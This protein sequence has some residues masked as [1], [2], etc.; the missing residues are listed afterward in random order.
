M[1][2][3]PSSPRPSMRRPAAAITLAALWLLCLLIAPSASA[4]AVPFRNFESPQVHPLAITPDGTRL[5][6]VNSPNGTLSVFQITSGS[7]VLTAEI[8]VGLEP[9]SVAARNDREAWIVNWLSDSVSIVDLTTGNVVRTIDVGDEPTDVLFGGSGR[10]MAFVCV[11]GGGLAANGI[12]G[13]SGVVKVFDPNNL[14]AAP[15]VIDVPGKQPRAL[16][17]STD[18]SRVF[19][20][21]FESGNQ[22]T[23]VPGPFVRDGGGLPPPSPSMRAGLPAAPVTGLIVKW[24]GG[25]WV[26]ETDRSWTRF[27]PYSLSDIDLIVIDATGNTVGT[28][29]GV[30]ELGTHVGNMAFD[31]AAQR[32]FVANRED[33][34]QVR[35][36][37]NL[38]GR[39]Q[40]SRVSVVN[41]PMGMQPSI[42]AVSDLNA[43]V[44]FGNPSGTDSE[45]S[46]SLA[47][48]ADI[49][50]QS[51]GTV[52]VAAT[53]SARVGVL[54]SSGAVRGR[55]NVGRGPTG[56]AL[57]GARQRLYV[58]NRFDETM[59]VVDTNS[60]TQV[61]QVAVGFNP[62]PASVRD[63]RRFLY[64]SSLSAH[65]TVSC[66][67]C[68]L[69]GH[70]DGMAWDLGD[71]QGNVDILRDFLGLGETS[72]SV[73]PM[74]G[75]MMTQSLRGLVGVGP[76]HWRGD[77][78]DIRA[79]NPA[80]VSLLGGTR[81]L[82]TEEMNA[83]QSFVLSITYPPNPNEKL[84]R[85]LT[86]QDAHARDLFMTVKL[87]TGSDGSGIKTCNECHQIDKFGTSGLIL[88]VSDI[89]L[90]EQPI[91]I[92]Q[93]RGLYQKTGMER[94][95]GDKRGTGFGFVRDG[96]F[97]TII[98]FLRAPTFIFDPNPDTAESQ[99]SDMEHML[100]AFD[101]GTAPTV[102]LMV[103]VNGD[104]KNSPEI[105]NRLQLLMQRSAAGDCDLVVHGL[106]GGG[107]H[108]FL[109]LADGTFQPDSLSEA[110]V[111]LQTLLNAAGAGA[112][113]TFTGVAPGEGRRRA[114]DGDGDGLL[115][116]DDPP[117]S[118]S[119]TG[120][121]VDAHGAGIAGVAVSLTGTQSGTA[122]TDALG[123][124]VFN[125]VLTS[126]THTVTPTSA[127]TTFTPASRT[128]SNPTWNQSAV[129]AASSTANASDSSEFF[130]AQHYRDFL[131]REPDASGLA[132]WTNEI[133]Q[134]GTNAQ[135]RELKRVNVSGAFFLSIEFQQTGYLVYRTSK[136][137][138]G[139]LANK[140][141]PVTVAR[142]MTDAQRLGR[143]VVV[144]RA[145]WEQLLETNKLAFF[146]G[147]VQRPEFI[148][149]YP[150]SMAPVDFVS[151]LNASAGFPLNGVEHASLVAQLS[152]NN[153]TQGRAAVLRQVAENAVFSARERNRAFV[154]MQYFGYLR[155]DPNDAP[156]PNLDFAGYN[157]WLT[158]LNDFDGNHVSA[159]MVKAFIAS[160]EYRHRFGQ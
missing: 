42:I 50:C 125:Y 143:G 138:F 90:G 144:G 130:V 39:F 103:T 53:G 22:T 105:V 94:S 58:L 25:A 81:Q 123:R 115:N 18:G 121:V 118:V 108:G 80:F 122:M 68:H 132:F 56:L 154:L 13:G 135:C 38:R 85:G 64:D 141:V 65:G 83:F 128:F 86:E 119:I 49:V 57:D 15:Q 19:V 46:L 120:Q 100:L 129:F 104:N 116:D 137:S 95:Q 140:P 32:L 117:S 114:I 149:R 54:N 75:P 113:L 92:P 155:R 126:G 145:G 31:P 69:N 151:L 76:L 9:V 10:E 6:A 20:S 153:T 98:N 3:Q 23:I 87:D 40:S 96:E 63:G 152:A 158:K 67:S 70:R 93:L 74:K 127:G 147:W 11:S 2:A 101:T 8:P 111:S 89:M 110:P 71:P 124:Y 112:E 133:E 37:P 106:Y 159:E 51:D 131:N 73:H 59:S 88:P 44:D 26:D 55:I 77:R 27:T 17:R 84:D 160:D 14:A 1:S 24:N 21:V 97:D 60:K 99:R 41:D 136:A 47:L 142:L 79:F 29:A 7:P 34:N 4:Q 148:A 16:A 35:F 150:V 139:D 107:P 78:A 109:R 102:G 5:L 62:E 33:I 36:E 48:P 156:E 82:T 157:F 43:H 146:N 134:C 91:K 45:R 66:A 30:R 28:A 52:Y 12:T 72:L 61:S